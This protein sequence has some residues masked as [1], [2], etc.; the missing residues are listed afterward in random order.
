MEKSAESRNNDIWLKPT[1]YIVLNV[2][3]S[4]QKGGL[5]SIS[6]LSAIAL[7][8]SI[9]EFDPSLQSRIGDIRVLGFKGLAASPQRACSWLE[10]L[11]HDIAS[12]LNG[13][14]HHKGCAAGWWCG[15]VTHCTSIKGFGWC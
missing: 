6:G 9:R 11:L 1:L 7:K 14:H 13:L 2:L 12:P 10:V 8:V 15:F 5:L 3:A 4:F